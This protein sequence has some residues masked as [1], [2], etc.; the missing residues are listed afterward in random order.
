M[1]EILTESFCE[2]C[3][4]RYTFE[5]VAPKARP[6]TKL[7]VLSKGLRNYVLSDETTLDEAFADA[8]SDEQRAVSSQQLDAFHK[9]FNFCMSCRQYTCANCWNDAEARCLTCAPHLGHEILPAPFPAVS[10]QPVVSADSNGNGQSPPDPTARTIDA[11]AW[12]TVD[13]RP[14]PP[15]DEPRPASEPPVAP[16]R[17]AAV[18]PVV[19]PTEQVT[20]E[21]ATRTGHEAAAAQATTAT[22]RTSSLFA[23]FRPD[24]GR[25][26]GSGEASGHAA[27]APELD[28]AVELEPSFPVDHGPVTSPPEPVV[29]AAAE[30]EREPTAAPEPEA[31]AVSPEAEAVAVPSEPEAVA[32]SPEPEPVV[33]VAA[34]PEIEPVVFTQPEPEPQPVAAPEPEVAAP[35]PEV[36][37]A[38]PEPT[39]PAETA[40][41]P[42]PLA[43]APAEP[44]PEPVVELQ[45]SAAPQPELVLAESPEPIAAGPEPVAARELEPAV[46]SEPAPAS[47]A[48]EPT[49]EPEPVAAVKPPSA[50]GTVPPA[51]VDVVETPTWRIV[52]PDSPAPSLPA[53]PQPSTTPTRPQWPVQQG[54]PQWPAPQWAA[55]TEPAPWAM[56]DAAA[57]DPRAFARPPRPA[58]DALWVESSRDVL[59][60][61]GSGVQA[62]V[63]CGL[64]LSATARFCRRCGTRQ[65]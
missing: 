3:G 16:E 21:P 39:P 12:P 61:P 36:A 6:L 23:R 57:R 51:P 54:E 24:H 56:P 35:E 50:P 59:D 7:K 4:T 5:A 32:V 27:P 29:V 42:E 41:E 20:D 65:G 55:P 1:P 30:P 11:S 37:A 46:A 49:A 18:E 62:C 22:A 14:T 60:R 64:P 28:E 63:S 15:A 13:L 2:R 45:P 47:V 58:S 26:E 40:L 10:V 38:S 25:G 48:A 19:T 9:A 53:T 43:V 52:A 31:V 34:E 8:R 44:E 33:F 17:Q